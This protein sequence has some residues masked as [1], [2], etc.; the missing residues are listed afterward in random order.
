MRKLKGFTL[1]ELL[2]VIAIIALLMAILLPALSKAREV[3]K[4]IVCGNQEKTFI[5]ANIIYSQSCDGKFVP[6]VANL[7]SSGPR[8]V[9]ITQAWLANNLFKTILTKTH[10]HNADNL[11]GT[12]GDSDFVMP[13]ELLCPDDE[14]SK[15]LQN[16]VTSEGTYLG[17]FG[18]N[19]TDFTKE[20]GWV[21][22]ISSWTN[23]PVEVCHISQNMK[24]P[25]EYLCFTEDPDW[26]VDWGGADY[27]KGW[28]SLG[29]Q[30]LDIYQ[31]QNIYGPVHYRHS[32]GA[33]VAF[34]DGHVSYMKKQNIFV[35]TDY[36]ARPSQPGMWVA[37]LPLYYQGGNP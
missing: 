5:M 9:P 6:I 17:S 23:N 3:A 16:A 13:T 18:Y 1:V 30:N 20:F 15:H 4:R 27:T 28:D 10:R 12:N 14:N 24:R 11:I 37:N 8:G 21:G 19:S 26:Y 33:N 29:Q 25:A 2:V 36:N 7:G 22:S 35:Q 31:Q 32:E 34:Y